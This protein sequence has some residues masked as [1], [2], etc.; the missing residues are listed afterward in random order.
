MTRDGFLFI[1]MGLR[2]A[3]ASKFKEQFISAFNDME[4]ELIKQIKPLSPM[5]RINQVSV[6]VNYDGGVAS[7]AGRTLM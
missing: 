6:M 2:G 7:E 5:D 4:I 1:C 3:K